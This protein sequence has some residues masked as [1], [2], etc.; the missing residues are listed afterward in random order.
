MMIH[1]VEGKNQRNKKYLTGGKR[2]IAIAIKIQ[3]KQKP[4]EDREGA[5]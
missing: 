2:V 5:L 1:V 3:F 4:K